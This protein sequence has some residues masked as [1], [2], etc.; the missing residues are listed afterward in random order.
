MWLFSLQINE[1][2]YLSYDRNKMYLFLC[3]TMSLAA[4]QRLYKVVFYMKITVK[5]TRSLGDPGVI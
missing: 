2:L 4:T 1:Q 3:N 5:V